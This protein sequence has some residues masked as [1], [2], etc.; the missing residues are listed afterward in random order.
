MSDARI[1]TVRARQ[2]FD[3]RGR[4]TVEVDVVLSDGTLG[5]A[6]VPSGASTGRHEAVE[7]RDGDAHVYAGRGVLNAVHN[8]EQRIAPLVRGFDVRLQ[9]E[10]DAHMCELDGTSDLRGVGANAVAGVSMAA[11]RAAAT[12]ERQPLFQRIAELGG[13]A[14]PV[15][16]LPM[17]NIL[18]GGAHAGRGMDLQDFMAIAVGAATLDDALAIVSRVRDAARERLAARGLPTLLA[19]EGGFAPGFRTSEE[20]LDLMVQAIEDAGYAPGRDVSIAI[21]VAATQLADGAGRYRLERSARTL[22]AD[23][24]VALVTEWLR[25]YPIVS[26]EDPLGEDDWNG[27][28]HLATQAGDVCQ[29]VGD[30]L[31]CTDPARIRRGIE[32]R[33]ANAVL[34][35]IN[36][37]GTLS[38]TLDALALARQHGYRTIV[39]ARSGETEDSFIADLAV[40]TAAGQIKI[41]SLS[42]SE[43]LAK[44][45]QLLR[46][47]EY[48]GADHFA[49]GRSVFTF[50]R[51]SS[52]RRS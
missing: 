8:V 38:G 5:R 32:E 31:F 48:L 46:I 2:V 17:V 44:Y 22:S 16:P 21:D 23:E 20:A 6:A 9:R 40:G 10:L 29:W 12:L 15:L 34:I 43:R 50:D 18:S 14:Q 28:R 52:A 51:I 26:I 47:Q 25:R 37:I 27:W 3:S 30:D 39:S 13:V 49:P 41:G 36:Q 4:P 24:L 19:D 7:L 45:N 33:V 11:C 1:E 35:K 42:T